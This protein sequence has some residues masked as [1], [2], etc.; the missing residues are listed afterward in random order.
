MRIFITIF[1]ILVGSLHLFAQPSNDDCIDAISIRSTDNFCSDP[2]QFNNVGATADPVT[3]EAV[4]ACVS[5]NFESGVWFTFAPR[6]PAV[7]ISVN[8]GQPL[9]TAAR[10]RAVLYT[11]SC[12]TGLTYVDCTPGTASFAELTVTDLTV[13]QRYYLYTE[14]DPDFQG[15]FQVC[16]NDFIAPPSPQSDCPDAVVLCDKSAFQVETL[17]TAGDDPNELDNLIGACLNS[18]FASSWYRWTCDEPG[19]LTFTLTPNDFVPGLESDDLDFALFELPGGIDDCANKQLLRCMASGETGGCDFGTWMIC[20]GPTGL[21][22]SSGDESE[23]AGCDQCSGGDD[24]NFVSPIIMQSGVS[25]ALVVMNFNRSGKGFSIEFGGTGTFLGPE[26]DFTEI[27]GNFI[28]CD[29]SVQYTDIS[30][31]GPDP[32]V[33]WSWNFGAGANPQRLPGQGPH[34]TTYISFGPKSVALTV[35]SESGCRVTEILDI[36]VEPCCQDTSTLGLRVEEF[37]ESCA[38]DNNGILQLTGISGSPEYNYSINGGPFEPSSNITSLP[39]GEYTVDIVDTKGCMDG[40]VAIIEPGNTIGVNAGDDLE[41]ELGLQGALDASIDP[42]G[43]NVT[44]MWNPEEGLECEGSDF[45]DCPN[46]LVVSPG[47]T[48]YTVTITDED[49]CTATDQVMVTTIFDPRIYAPTAIT[50]NSSDDEN[51]F[52]LG[53]GRGQVE[54]VT[55]FC[56]FDRWGGQVFIGNNIFLNQDSEMENGWNGRFGGPGASSNDEVVPGVYAWYA[57]VLFINGV[58]LSFA[59]D[60]TVIR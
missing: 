41:I 32:I 55:T 11:G 20:N 27:L 23:D 36:F 44:Y 13:G 59:G 60:I 56:I 25:Y 12:T 46:P 30:T 58:T 39:P 53:F 9:G 14:S 49:G 1:F 54:S 24:D 8:S 38:G 42:M 35:E 5:I 3:Q 16:I 15:T 26:P 37:P 4:D 34:E 48:T 2:M 6:E 7:L 52:R 51:I 17:A 22:D 19:S 29:K 50:P 57:D 45:V 40:T 28:E 33:E 18:E 31:P 21:R 47:N 10:I 43:N